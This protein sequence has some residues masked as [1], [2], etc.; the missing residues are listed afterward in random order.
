MIVDP[1]TMPLDLAD[2][3]GVTVC[4]CQGGGLSQCAAF[5][6]FLLPGGQTSLRRWHEEAEEFPSVLDGT[7]ALPE[8]EGPRQIGRATCV[9]SPA[10]RD[11]A[12]GLRNDVT[13]PATLIIVGSRLAEDPA[14]YP[15]IDLHYTRRKGRRTLARKDGPPIP[16]G[17]GRWAN[18]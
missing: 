9:C 7:A 4:R 17:H 18:D 3:G 8:D 11:D 6:E 16:A 13:A 15:D 2:N 12:H 10:G 5:P 1:D 14:H